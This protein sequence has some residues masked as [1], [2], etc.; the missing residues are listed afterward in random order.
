LPPR[1]HDCAIMRA[2]LLLNKAPHI[3]HSYVVV[4]VCHF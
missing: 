4:R 3:V 1:V 2:C